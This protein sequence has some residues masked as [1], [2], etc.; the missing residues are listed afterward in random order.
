V[1]DRPVRPFELEPEPE[2]P[3]RPPERPRAAVLAEEGEPGFDAIEV[4]DETEA[5]GDA[6]RRAGADLVRRA[7][8]ARRRALRWLA[9]GVAVMVAVLVG[10][11]LADLL[12]AAFARSAALGAVLAAA[13]TVIL[14]ALAALAREEM[15]DLRRLSDISRLQADAAR[16]MQPGAQGAAAVLAARVEALYRDRPDVAPGLEAF[17][18]A[19]PDAHGDAETLALLSRMVLRPVDRRARRVV[20]IE[21]GDDEQAIGADEAAGAFSHAENLTSN[22]ANAAA[23]PSASRVAGM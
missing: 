18:A 22:R 3:P 11:E 23:P 9:G 19:L 14:A 8:R 2:A 10:I 12:R 21:H 1:S 20:I 17:R 5:P 16:S 7:T 15:R 4:L 13:A 6:G